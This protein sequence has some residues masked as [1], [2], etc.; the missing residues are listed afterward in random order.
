MPFSLLRRI[1]YRY[2]VP[3]NLWIQ[4]TSY[5]YRN[6][7]CAFVVAIRRARSVPDEKEKYAQCN[8]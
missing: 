1:C 6:W 8:L 2:R 7:C 3:T 5:G 4:L